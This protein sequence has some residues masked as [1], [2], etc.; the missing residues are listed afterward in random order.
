MLRFDR[1]NACRIDPRHLPGT[2]ADGALIGGIDDGITLNELGDLPGKQQICPL[3]LR[4]QRLLA[5]VA[6]LETAPVTK[7]EVACRQ[8]FALQN[9]D[10]GPLVH[11]NAITALPPPVRQ[12][13]LARLGAVH[14]TLERVIEEGVRDKQ[15]R[16]VPPGIVIQLLTGALN[17]GM[18][19][20]EWQSIESIERSAGDYFSVF[21]H[22]LQLSRS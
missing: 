2:D 5:G 17:A 1:R 14:G 22:G 3:G 15:L 7:L 4:G 9:S 10:Q 21:F 12:R 13:L 18:D 20:E 6:S 11:F 8:I 16:P 19:L